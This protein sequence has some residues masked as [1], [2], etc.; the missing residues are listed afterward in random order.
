MYIADCVMCAG[1]IRRQAAGFK[2]MRARLQEKQQA[3]KELTD[4]HNKTARQLEY[5]Y[6]MYAIS[7]RGSDDR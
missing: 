3:L 6:G 4:A 2:A 7:G 1:K 5:R